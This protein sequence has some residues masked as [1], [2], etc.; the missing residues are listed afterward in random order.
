[1]YPNAAAL[2]GTFDVEEGFLFGFVFHAAP[3]RL[4][5]LAID[6]ALGQAQ[7]SSGTTRRGNAEPPLTIN[8]YWRRRQWLTSA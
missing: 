7:T 4:A 3:P 5:I 8:A 2:I 1:V 6:A